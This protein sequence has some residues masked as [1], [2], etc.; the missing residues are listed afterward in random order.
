MESV[1]YIF[2]GGEGDVWDAE[3]KIVLRPEM[4]QS[5]M[6]RLHV[7]KHAS[8]V[9]IERESEPKAKSK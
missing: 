4:S 1:N 8:V 7:L 9:K 5:E 3:G 6:A 2:V